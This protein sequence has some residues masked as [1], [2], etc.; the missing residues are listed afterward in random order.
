MRRLFLFMSIIILLSFGVSAYAETTEGS[1]ATVSEPAT[2]ISSKK[3]VNDVIRSI[4]DDFDFYRFMEMKGITDDEV[5]KALHS[6]ECIAYIKDEL[7]TLPEEGDVSANWD[8]WQWHLDKIEKFI[9]NL[10]SS[11]NSY[12]SSQNSNNN[13]YN[14]NNNDGYNN[15]MPPQMPYGNSNGWGQYPPMPPS[16]YNRHHR[17]N[18]NN[19]SGG[20][21][22][23]NCSNCSNCMYK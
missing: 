7:K 13:G 5:D 22:N 9:E 14:G 19:W 4:R 8:I 6:K 12:N 3:T 11:G 23:C 16:P 21:C 2:V 17:D 10:F 1:T 20:T 18:H 15:M